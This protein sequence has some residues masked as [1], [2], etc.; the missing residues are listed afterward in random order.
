MRLKFE[1]VIVIALCALVGWF[2]VW[3]VQSNGDPW[4][5]G[6]EQ[7]DYYNLLIDGWLDGHLYLK[8]PVPAALLALKDPYDPK[9]R[10]SGLGLHDA[11]FYQGKYYVYF[12]AA[13]VVTVMLPFRLLTGRDLPLAAAVIG[14]V[15]AGF[16]A[17]AA[18]WLAL[19]RRYFP[20]SGMTTLAIGLLAL[21][22]VS[23]GPLLLRRPHMWELSIAAGYGFAMLTLAG[24]YQSLHARRRVAWL[25]GAG[26]F[27][28]LA[29]ASRPSYLIASP[30]LV[31]PLMVWWREQ[32]RLPWRELVGLVTPLAFVGSLMALHNYQRFGD[33]FQFGQAYQFS[34]DYESK[35]THFSPGYWGFNLWR[36]FF[37]LADWSRYFPF[38]QPAVMPPK[39]PGFGGHDDVYGLLM[40]FPLAWLACAAPLA[41]W[42]RDPHERAPLGAWVGAVTILFFIMALMM[43][44]FF[45]SA[46][47]YMVDF[48]PTLILLA[49][50]GLLGLERRAQAWRSHFLRGSL[51]AAW[52]FAAAFS[53]MFAVLYP[54]QF[55]GFFRE[56]NAPREFQVAKLLNR[57][58]AL[59]ERWSSPLYGPMILAL[60]LPRDRLGQTE[61]LLTSGVVGATDRVM[62]RYVDT[63]HVQLGFAHGASREQWSRPVPVDYTQSHHVTIEAGALYPPESHPFFADLKASEVARTRRRLR[64]RWNGEPVLESWQHFFN[65]SPSTLTVAATLKDDPTTHRFSGKV[66][67]VERAMMTPR[68]LQHEAQREHARLRWRLVEREP[69]Q[70]EALVN[71]SQA[72]IRVGSLLVQSLGGGRVQFQVVGLGP[73]SA[74]MAESAPVA[75]RPSGV[76]EVKVSLSSAPSSGGSPVA[77]SSGK[78]RLQV[79]VDQRIVWTRAID[80]PP[81]AKLTSLGDATSPARSGRDIAG[82]IFSE[83]LFL[84]DHDPLITN[85]GPLRLRVRFPLGKTGR[86]EPLLV[87]GQTGAGNLLCVE[88]LDEHTVRLSFDHWGQ[89]TLFSEPWRIDYAQAQ[90]FEID[91]GGFQVRTG[92]ARRSAEPR[93]PF[94]VRVNRQTVWKT[95]APCYASEPETIFIGYDPLG[96]STCDPAFTGEI[97]LAT[98]SNANP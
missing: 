78:R 20:K 65:A 84:E 53:V 94:E 95:V 25:V 26:W 71:F 24:L 88:Y 91:W 83:E 55:A 19:R 64:L 44:S 67:S 76:H 96:A 57:V 97:L 32:R 89:G 47:R 56:R 29:I 50:V 69:G 23:L 63:A 40:N 68:A 14:F 21:G 16:L 75:L 34:F 39:P 18:A 74:T 22:F 43:L 27:L 17:S 93:V 59:A 85:P 77:K 31:A 98:R 86:R 13:P 38:I 60:E 41:F 87:T 10:P 37:S 48:S 5:F 12:G 35:V 61:P 90:D 45:G 6:Q 58:P 7:N 52:S 36:Y 1:R 92:K 81:G 70:P 80:L 79:S 3:T 28:G 72:G 62:I 42:R 82:N 33:P 15:Y 73:T 66:L 9:I 46:G 8:V 54:L 51:R 4:K 2:D 11:S 49:C 30:L